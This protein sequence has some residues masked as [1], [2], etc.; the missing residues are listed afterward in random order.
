[1]YQA[2]SKKTRPVVRVDD[3]SVLMEGI[4]YKKPNVFDKI[5]RGI[6]G[7]FDK[8]GVQ[9]SVTSSSKKGKSSYTVYVPPVSVH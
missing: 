1:D 8:G 6:K 7:F 2:N 9:E 4:V 5:G 3:E